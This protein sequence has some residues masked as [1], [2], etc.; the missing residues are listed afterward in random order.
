MCF[1][2][3]LWHNDGITKMWVKTTTGLVNLAH[4]REVSY[5]ESR[6]TLSV[7]WTGDLPGNMLVV[8]NH[9]GVRQGLADLYDTS[10][11]QL[12]GVEPHDWLAAVDS[13]LRHGQYTG[14]PLASA[15]TV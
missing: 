9:Q 10:R 1:A 13:M 11:L 2:A 14:N 7:W 12:L 5:D 4:A 3:H 6:K 8:D 15:S